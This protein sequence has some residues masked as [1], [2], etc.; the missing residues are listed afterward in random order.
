MQIP[1]VEGIRPVDTT[2]AGDSFA[3]GFIYGLSQGW[4]LEESAR[5]G[6]EC[7]ARAVQQIGATTW[8]TM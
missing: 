4:S 6:N 8:I 5:F 2:G 3:A 1:A 7:G